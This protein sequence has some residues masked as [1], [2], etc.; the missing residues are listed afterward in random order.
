MEAPVLASHNLTDTIALLSRTPAALDAL[1]R[2]LPELWTGRN[3]GDNSWSV[4]DVVGHLIHG[5]HTDWMPRARMILQFGETRAFEPFDRFAQQ[6]E[7]EGNV[8]GPAP[9]RIRYGTGQEPRGPARTE[10]PARGT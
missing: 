9:G 1:L 3:E 6:L 10:S 4:Y 8:T 5:E 7:S 2:D